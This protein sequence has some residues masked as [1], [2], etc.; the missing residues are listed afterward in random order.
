MLRLLFLGS[1]ATLLLLSACGSQSTTTKPSPTVDA[2][3][4]TTLISND[5]GTL[6]SDFSAISTT[7]LDPSDPSAAEDAINTLAADVASFQNDLTTN[8][9][10][11]QFKKSATTMQ[12]ALGDFSTGCQDADTGLA[13]GDAGPLGT[14]LTLFDQGNALL[15]AATSELG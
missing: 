9:A 1:A 13:G 14:A 5:A 8:P 15:S 6:S 10:P 4:W 2:G 3:A 7:S 12:S 11:P